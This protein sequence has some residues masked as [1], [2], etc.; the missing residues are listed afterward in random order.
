MTGNA[1]TGDEHPAGGRLRLL[2]RAELDAEQVKLSD[3]LTAT[4]VARGRRAGYRAALDDGRLVGPF[5]ALL[6]TPAIAERQLD[7]AEAISAADL[8][9]AAREVAILTVAAQ[10][11]AQYVLYAHS[12]AAR[13]AG[14][15][16][17]AVA[18]LVAARTP[19]GLSRTA[20]LAH[21]VALALVRDHDVPDD[22][23][24]DLLSEY[25]ERRVVVLIALIGQYLATC[26]VIT[27]FR[28]PM[29]GA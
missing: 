18:D 16:E 13:G 14:L 19:A 24:S 27:C 11:R 9:P 12:A 5:N 22:L 26:A 25:G 10:W 1:P 21:D 29:P 7:W 8:N 3:R 2:H 15:S 28:V 4:R 6:R 20:R 23:Y 17:V